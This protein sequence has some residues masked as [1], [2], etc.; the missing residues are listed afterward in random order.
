M[1]RGIA[2]ALALAVLLATSTLAQARFSVTI[3]D[4]VYAD[5]QWFTVEEYQQYKKTHPEDTKAPAQPMGQQPAAAAGPQ[6]TANTPSVPEKISPPSVAALPAPSPQPVTSAGSALRAAS[7]KTTKTYEEFPGEGEKFDC[8]PL[9]QL[10]RQEM[11]AQGWK[12]DFVEKLPSA[13]GQAAPSSYKI[14]LSR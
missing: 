10:T 3:G 14:I 9:G 2:G 11:L 8:G 13:Q 4:N 5:G 12:V 1:N 7:C 6:A